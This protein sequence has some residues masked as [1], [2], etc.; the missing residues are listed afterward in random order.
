MLWCGAMHISSSFDSGN[1]EV[2]DD[3]DPSAVRLRI[4]KDAGE[5]HF[6]WFHFRVTAARGKALRL[7]IENAGEASYPEGFENYR[8]CVSYDRVH[9]GRVD[10]TFDGKVLTIIDTPR[11]DS[12]YYSYFAPYSLERHAD[13]V[14]HAVCQPHVQ[15]QRLGASCEG[16]DMDLLRIGQPDGDKKVCWIIARQHPGETMAEWLVEGLLHRLFDE[17][18]P[19]AAALLHKAVFYV[20]PNMNPD[21]S[22]RGHLRNNAAGMN[23]NRA[24]AEPSME[25]SPEVFLVRQKME[26][27]GVDFFLDVHGDEGLPYNFIAGS[28]GIPRWNQRLAQLQGRY[29]DELL[30][31]TPEFQKEFGYPVDPPGQANLSMGAHFVGER[32]DCLSMTLEQPFK[33]AANR[34][35][36]DGWSPKRARRLGQVQL[37]ALRTLIDSLR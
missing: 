3:K 8:A 27:T 22:F 12:V 10:T 30:R 5:D 9:F 4:R 34:P 26:Q 13:L 20:V 36:R 33:D 16:R 32:F 29:V 37:D 21:G 7:Q 17:D 24:W 23:L 11:L 15:Y 35:H 18:D 25:R 2:I 14:A 1:I 31:I 19:V 28:D 6:Q